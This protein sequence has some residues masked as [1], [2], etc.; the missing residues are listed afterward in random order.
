MKKI[1]QLLLLSIVLSSINFAQDLPKYMTE[2]EKILWQTYVPSF[3]PEFAAPPPVPVRT[4]AEWEELQGLM[5]TWTS[6]TTILREIVRHAQPECRVYIVCSDSNTVKNFLTSGNVPIYNISFL[7]YPFN[8]I[9]IRDYGPW[10]VYAEGSDSLYI[11]DWVYNRPRPS[12]DNISLLF[13][14]DMNIPI[15]QTTVEPNRLVH[16]GGNFMADGFATGF[17]SKLILN[18]NSGKTEAQINAIMNS[19]MGIDPHIKMDNLPYDGIHHIDMH[20]KLLDEETLLVGQYP[21]GVS[22]GPYIEANLQYVLNNFQTA[23]GKPF[24]VV[25][26]PMPPDQFGR[27]PNAGGY[28]RTYTN[29][30]IVNKTVI[31]PTYDLQ[32]DTTALRIYR[33]AMPGYNVVGIDCNAIIPQ[34]GA[35]HCI[36][37][38]VGTYNPLFIS[39]SPV[40]DTLFTNEQIEIKAIIKNQSGIAQADLFW[41]SDTSLGYSSVAMNYLSG[42]TLVGFIPS[43][44]QQGEVFYYI[45]AES[46]NGK[47][48]TKPMTAPQGFYKFYVDD[49]VPVELASFSHSVSGNNVTLSWVTASEINNRGFEIE[50]SQKS[51]RQPTDK[52]QKWE[53]IGFVEGRGTTTDVQSYTFTEKNVS[54]G[55]YQYRLKQID[56]D[57]SFEYSAVVEVSVNIPQEFS[58]EQ[59]YP[60]PFNPSTKIKYSIPNVGTR[61]ALSVTLKVYNILGVEV[62]TLV[63][64]QKQPGIYEIEFNAHNLPAGRQGLSSGTYFYTIIADGFV[65]TKKMIILK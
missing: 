51:I 34:G 36:V 40:R 8:S 7:I 61:L 45:S 48:M 56:F 43:Q 33:E 47:T 28:Y 65:H 23:Y 42:D 2:E 54:I 52:S 26:I 21:P 46:V 1:L 25:R 49:P 55:T 6:H 5:L 35:I 30:V 38:E 64:E 13:A 17:S 9:W 57:E 18:E 63:N 20:I 19:F 27:Y 50:R 44:T 58:L 4:M 11:I 22:D 10:S 12:D 15:Y 31:V 60:N 39:H 24:K 16:T 3:N 32:Y 62:A 29:S 53:R 41:S 14:N 37:K 59:N